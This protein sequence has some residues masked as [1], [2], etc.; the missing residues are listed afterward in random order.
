AETLQSEGRF[1]SALSRETAFVVNNLLFAGF[2]F[3][4][5]LGTMFPLIAEAA[6]GVKVS[7][8]GPYF[9]QMSVPIALMLVFLAGVGPALPWRKG[10]VDQ[11]KGKFLWPTVAAIAAGIV[12]FVLGVRHLLAWLTFVLAVFAGGLLIAEIFLPLRARRTSTGEGWGTAL[13]QLFTGNRRR[14]G[15][16]IV[17]S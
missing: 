9:S 14:Y 12:L 10:S 16:Y 6:R 5:L 17:H 13:W 11:L 7:V 1:D 4:V 2:A 3:I 8:G 15:G